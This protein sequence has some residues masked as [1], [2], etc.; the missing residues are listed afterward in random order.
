MVSSYDRRSV[1]P[2]V[3]SDTDTG[4]YANHDWSNY[5]G[6]EAG[7]DGREEFV[8]LDVD[9]P[10][11]IVR[12]WS[13]TPNGILR[14][15]FD[16]ATAPVLEAPMLEL[17]SGEVVPFLPPFA[18]TTAGGWNME[19]PFPFRKHAK[20][21]WSGPGGF[22]QITYRKYLEPSTDVTSFDP[23][24]LDVVRLDAVKSQLQAPATPA[25]STRTDR[26]VLNA[27]FPEATVPASA[28]GEE[29]VELQVLPSVV[30]EIT[31]RQSILS[32]RFDRTETVRTPLGDFFGAGPGLLPH[33][34]LPLEMTPEGLLRSRFLMPFAEK[35]VVRVDAVNGVDVALVLVHRPA[36]FQ[37]GTHYFHAH[38]TAR[39]PMS[40]R[41]YRDILL[42]DLT[43][44]GSYVGTFLAVGNSSLAWWGEGDDKVWVDDDTFPSQFGTGTEDFFGQ[45]YSSPAIYDHPYRAQSKAAGG[46]GHAQGLFSLLRVNIL[47]P[48]RFENAHRF[49]LELWHWDKDSQVTFDTIS[50]FYLAPDGTDNLPLADS[51]DF[52]LSPF[53]P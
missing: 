28:G 19:F 38:W 14:L 3:S 11:A 45:G 24:G 12:M 8:L 21:A 26:F 39:G 2:Q 15:Y 18:G 27:S 33:T 25:T 31:L 44:Q 49:N 23:A 41:P 46:F 16:G 47:D 37:E 13:A 48:I 20:V 17:F 50:Y 4:W 29:I 34:T 9:G 30:D 5:L 52:R 22:Y 1:V 36:A 53:G 7:P 32:I 10:G 6:R 40:S 43:G 51:A 35:A 42:A